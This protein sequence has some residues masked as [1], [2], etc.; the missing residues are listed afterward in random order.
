MRLPKVESPVAIDAARRRARRADPDHG[1]DRDRPGAGSGGGDR[2][3]PSRDV[4]RA[5]RG[6]PGQRPRHADTRVLDWARVELLVA[7][8]AAGKPPPMMAVFTDIGDLDGLGGGHRTRPADGLRRPHGDPSRASCRSSPPRSHPTNDEVAWAS[9]VVA[10]TAAGGVTTLA[11]GEMVDPRCAGG[12]SA[13]SPCAAR[14]RPAPRTVMAAQL[15]LPRLRSGAVRFRLLPTDDKFFDLF[16]DA[17]A[18]V[19][20]CGRR[21]RELLERGRRR[22]ARRPSSRASTAATSS[23]ATSSSG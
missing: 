23:P 3:P 22:R 10:A 20:D 6:R 4:G 9:A 17:A 14:R 7:A 8:R 18:N 13:S 2:R 1:P 15:A 19:A 21:L 12:P 5:R 16:N 11:S